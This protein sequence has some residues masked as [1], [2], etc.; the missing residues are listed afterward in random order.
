MDLSR[1]MVHYQQVEESRLKR[2][3]R[4]IKRPSLFEGGISKGMFDIQD[5]PKFKKRFSN[6]APHSFPKARKDRVY[7]PRHQGEK[8]GDSQNEKPN[9]A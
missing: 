2:K 7:K 4:E 8:S 6:H 3:N 5:K 1:L 9:C